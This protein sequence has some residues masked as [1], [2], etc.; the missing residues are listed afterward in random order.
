M[1]HIYYRVTSFLLIAAGQMKYS[2]QMKYPV[3]EV[4]LSPVIVTDIPMSNIT[5]NCSVSTQ[6]NTNFKIKVNWTFN[7]NNTHHN[8]LPTSGNNIRIHLEKEKYWSTLTVT[9]AQVNNSGWYFCKAIVDIPKLE[10]VWSSG[11]RVFVGGN[12][13]LPST[14][15]VSTPTSILSPP[16]SGVR[17]WMWVGAGAGGAVVIVLILFWILWRRKRYRETENPVYENTQ[18]KLQSV[19][20]KQPSPRPCVQTDQSKRILTASTTPMPARACEKTLIYQ[21]MHPTTRSGAQKV[22]AQTKLKTTA[23]ENVRATKPARK[24]PNKVRSRV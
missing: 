21:N 16:L 1:D 22:V 20:P 12:T 24:H 14:M 7:F 11:S 10:T 6:N 8:S 4:N 5:L 2:G 19:G 17:V 18:P 23:Y 3:M 15:M 9:D 13:T